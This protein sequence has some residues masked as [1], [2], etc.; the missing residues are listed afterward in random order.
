MHGAIMRAI[1]FNKDICDIRIKCSGS[2]SPKG[3]PSICE[4]GHSNYAT[5]QHVGLVLFTGAICFVPRQS[6]QV[7]NGVD[8]FQVVR[9]TC[10][11][12]LST[13]GVI[14]MDAVAIASKRE[15]SVVVI[16]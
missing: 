14:A 5:T 2:N 1:M 8:N 11:Q 4:E 6:C 10:K 16:S 15:P 7:P 12:W 13:L 3:R 9:I